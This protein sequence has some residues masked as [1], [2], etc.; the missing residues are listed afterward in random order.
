MIHF[1]I[2]YPTQ[3]ESGHLI[4]NELGYRTKFILTLNCSNPVENSETLTTR[5]KPPSY[6]E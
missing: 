4:Q 5:K 1:V 2:Q 6:Q 3:P